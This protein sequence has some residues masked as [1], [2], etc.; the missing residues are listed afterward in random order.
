M[1]RRLA[2]GRHWK[3]LLR[4]SCSP[5]PT[6]VTTSPAWTSSARPR[7]D[8]DPEPSSLLARRGATASGH[9]LGLPPPAGRVGPEPL[10]VVVAAGLVHE[11]VHHHVA[12]VEQHPTS[13]VEALDTQRPPA[14]RLLGL[15]FDLLGDRAD[16]A[17]VRAA[18]DHERI[19]DGQQPTH[20]QDHRALRL[21]RSRRPGRNGREGPGVVEGGRAPGVAHH[22]LRKSFPTMTVTSTTSRGRRL[23]TSLPLPNALC[24]RSATACFAGS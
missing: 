12:V 1:T 17:G 14:A 16:L 6:P 8:S 24:T 23:S 18:G 20:L 10:E 15:G 5:S 9:R 3:A 21:L 4:R 11:H 19:R 2:S 22:P 13:V 7:P